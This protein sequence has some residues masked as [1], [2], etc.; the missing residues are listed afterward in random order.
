MTSAPALRQLARILGDDV[1]RCLGTA[2]GVVPSGL[3]AEQRARLQQMV[4]QRLDDIACA[5]VAEAAACDDVRDAPSALVYLEDRLAV[6]GQFL[7]P[8][9]QE[10]LR[11]G[12]RRRTVQWGEAIDTDPPQ[13]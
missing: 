10:G 5:L 12:F 1:Y 9:Q 4:S 11:E 13:G 3:S 2:L 8:E 7:T 6:L